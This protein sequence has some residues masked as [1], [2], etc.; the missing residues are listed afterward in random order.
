MVE[1]TF[2]IDEVFYGLADKTRRDILERVAECEMTVSQIASFYE[3]SL[4]AVAKHL[5]ILEKVGL[6]TKRKEGRKQ[7]VALSPDAL[8]QADEYLEQYRAMWQ[9]R[10]NKLDNLLNQE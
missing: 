8:K 2:D 3:M 6:V 7:F 4:A 9:S 10:Y 5:S 1:Y